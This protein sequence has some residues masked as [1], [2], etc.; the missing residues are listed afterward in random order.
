MSSEDDPERLS[1]IA[2]QW[3]LVQNAHGESAEG[4]VVARG[5]LLDHYNS[6]VYRY[7]LGAV[8]DPDVAE[9]LS[10]DF[11]LRLLRGDFRRANP[12]RGRFRDYVKS[13][14]AN[15]VNDHFRWQRR[16]PQPLDESAAAAASPADAQAAAVTFE[17]CLRDTVLE[18]TWTALESVQPN[19][20][21]VL[22]LRVE[23]A[24]ISS[25]EMAQR[26]S[27]ANAQRWT[28]DRARKTLERARTKFADLLLDE[29]ASSLDC[30]ES[31]DLGEALV[32]LDL[33]RFCRKALERR[34]GGSLE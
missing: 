7:L 5:K 31:D 9:E 6:S 27:A 11:A 12:E 8:R 30:S 17:D 24:G 22:R 13:T 14:L 10:Q 28:A 4:A 33:L 16:Q 3:G 19:Y 34:A 32:E 15:L 25:S 26:L 23:H 20:H 18:R 2:T 21:L 29:V 1:R